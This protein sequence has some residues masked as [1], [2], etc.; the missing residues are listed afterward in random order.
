[1]FGDKLVLHDVDDQ[2]ALGENID[3]YRRSALAHSFSERFAS[4]GYHHFADD[5]HRAFHPVHRL[6]LFENIAHSCSRSLLLVHEK[7]HACVTGGVVD[8]KVQSL[9]ARKIEAGFKMIE[10]AVPAEGVREGRKKRTSE[11]GRT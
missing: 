6:D 3:C 9:S 2:L 11:W 1:M 8:R 4:L 7:N 10:V 5:E